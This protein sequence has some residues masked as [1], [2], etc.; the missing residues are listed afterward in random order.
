MFRRIDAREIG[1]LLKP[2]AYRSERGVYFIRITSYSAG[3]EGDL[4]RLYAEAKAHGTFIGGRLPNPDGA[5][6]QAFGAAV[7]EAF[8][9][10]AAFVAQAL[11]PWTPEMGQAGREGFADGVA[12]ALSA[13]AAQNKP[14]S[15]QRNL[16]V[17]MMIW[18]RYAC[19]GMTARLGGSD[20]AKVFVW[21]RE[22]LHAHELAFYQALNSA[23]ADVILL[24]PQG[25]ESYIKLD[26]AGDKCQ[27]LDADG[28]MPFPAAFSPEGLRLPPS[29]AAPAAPSQTA[30]PGLHVNVTPR[31][32]LTPQLTLD[33]S[34]KPSLAPQLTLDPQPKPAPAQPVVPDL[35][36][37]RV[38]RPRPTPQLTL[39]PTAPTR[40]PASSP[41]Q[42]DDAPPE[43]LLRRFP[44]PNKALR[45]NVWMK[46][47]ELD[48]VLKP[49]RERDDDLDTW[50]N[51]F[52][53]VTGAK[54][55]QNYPAELYR[56]YQALEADSRPVAVVDGALEPP[57]PEEIARI[58][59]H[60]YRTSDELIV[61]IAGNLPVCASSELQRHLQRAFV[62]VMSGQA[63]VQ[64]AINRLTTDAVYLLC[65]IERYQAQLYHGWKGGEVP[66]F[67]HMGPC[68][69]QRE[70][71]YLKFLSHIP[72]DVI[73]FAPDLGKKCALEDARLLDIRYSESLT[74]AAFPR[75]GADTRVQTVA[76]MAQQEL[77]SVLYTGDGLYRD[78]QFAAAQA[79]T[80]DTTIDEISTLWEQELRLRPS[81][82]T[83]QGLVTMPV[84][85]AR[86]SGVEGGRLT[87]Y[88]QSIKILAD[89][90]D[91]TLISSLPAFSRD[92]RFGALAVKAVKNGRVMR[93][94]I[95]ADRNYP[96]GILNEAT[97]EHIFDKMQQMIDRRLIRGT[98]ENGMEYA[99]VATVLGLNKDYL[100]A[101]Q[102]FDF[103][104]RNPKLVV[105]CAGERP[106][107]VEDA[108]M[109]MFLHLLGYDIVMFVPTGYQTIE[110]HLLGEK[111]VDHQAGEYMYDLTVPNMDTVQ[112]SR[113]QQI[114]FCF[115]RGI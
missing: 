84:I 32:R 87:Q 41:A 70:A 93:D 17:K 14:Q 103:T 3:L 33:P 97:Q 66:V 74:L 31:A 49:Q 51:A 77:D 76:S 12:Q 19:G 44:S 91:T 80:L 36:P 10:T 109:L 61:D 26:P 71:L 43:A 68:A 35:D 114:K 95:R 30:T 112:L 2:L 78:R 75:E 20:A 48:A 8:K 113:L 98:F 13:L 22:G 7:G 69:D 108:I 115:R 42:A 62:T 21:A 104:R 18:L 37:S 25:E 45:T 9:P 105:I 58:R 5:Q 57:T 82:S 65:W 92:G 89:R 102:R 34:P 64:S 55:K 29:P 100:R 54:N 60:P 23:G 88:W 90:G 27:R 46:A 72:C 63:R 24:L 79:L 59:R 6:L 47:A 67:I 38:V 86:V 40:A 50:C 1:D 94:V 106:P 4:A 83:S 110:Q 107:A 99:I 16:Y 85:W 39:T 53:R 73:I 81:F 56:F 28:A 11:A 52:I 15:V 101:I 96:F 111:P